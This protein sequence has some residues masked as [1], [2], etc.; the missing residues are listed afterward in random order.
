MR[1]IVRAVSCFSAVI[2]VS[3]A[4]SAFEPARIARRHQGRRLSAA[5]YATLVEQVKEL[6][7]T[8]ICP[9]DDVAAYVD[10]ELSAQEAEEFELHVDQ[11]ST[12]GRALMQQ[13]QFLA[14]LSASL[15]H[16]SAIDLPKD[17]TKR[18]VTNAES[19]VSGVRRPHELF[20]AICIS[21]ALFL[22]V[23]FAFGGETFA[24]ASAA[25]AIG[26]KVFVI[27]SFFLKTAGNAIFA[28]AVVSRSLAGYFNASVL[29][30]SAGL[31]VAALF[32]V[33]SSRW[34][35]RRRSA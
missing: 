5:G 12:C 16:G 14:A 7:E 24:F 3:G 2:G 4:L 34:M 35:L 26:E 11:C 23:L 1:S 29:S 10:G 31:V 13:R 22:F 30:I 27:G 32:I 19:S 17:F 9:R 18:I 8:D 21:A 15:D 33:F 6:S 25:G 20:T 28:V